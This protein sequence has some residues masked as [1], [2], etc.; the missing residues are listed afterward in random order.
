MVKVLFRELAVRLLLKSY[1]PRV[2]ELTAER[3]GSRTQL[4][5][6]VRIFRTCVRAFDHK[7][8]R[9]EE[10][11]SSSRVTFCPPMVALASHWNTDD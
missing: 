3:D 7:S 5:D 10:P 2:L 8:H 9:K 6:S 4:G 1:V 11:V